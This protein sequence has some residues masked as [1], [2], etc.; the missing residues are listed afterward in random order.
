[1]YLEWTKEDT[2]ADARNILI[3][4]LPGFEFPRCTLAYGESAFEATLT[5]EEENILAHLM[6]YTWLNRQIASIENI[7]M[8][9]S[10]SDFK[11]TSQ[12]NHLSKLIVLRQ[13]VEKQDR[14]MQRLYKRRKT[15][16]GRIKSNW[17]ILMEKSALE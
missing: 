12:A 8:K 1:M 7:R 15:E 10:G 11:M 3:D 16:N 14:R 4:A 9:Y 5:D 13:E 2:E 6:L 17:S